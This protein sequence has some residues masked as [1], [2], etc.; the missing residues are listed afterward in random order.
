MPCENTTSGTVRAR[1]SRLLLSHPQAPAAS[2]DAD[3]P[4]APLEPG[5]LPLVDLVSDDLRLGEAKLGRVAF[6][7]ARID[8]G[9]KIAALSTGGGELKLSAAGAWRRQHALSSAELN[10]E[11]DSAAI[12]PALQGLGY[13]PNLEAQRSQFKGKLAWTPA[14][15]GLEWAQ[16]RGEIDLELEKGSLR[17]V[18]PGAG[19]V[20]GLLNFTALPR[21]LFLDFRDVT[22]KGLSFD[23]VSG[24]F[25]LADGV[26][27]TDNVEI[28]GP[29]V[30]M[31]MR[32]SVGLAARTYDQHVTV[33]PDVS[34]GVTL[35]ALLLGG[36]AA[37]IIALI[38]Q[39]VLDGPASKLSQFSYTV[40][41]SWDNPQVQ[42]VGE[43]AVPPAPQ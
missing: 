30:K 26:A 8:G 39:E 7:T 4:Q 3:G 18:E 21:R 1:F 36:P 29:S 35:G 23:Q 9:Q 41:G 28:A 27:K 25:T 16:A 37:G 22:T 24:R 13:T 14:A 40:T 17:A 19:R 15:A 10:F 34:S 11:L 43:D 12:G 31:E 2:D 33:Y 6:A 32:G 38:A 5:A 42:R 20:L